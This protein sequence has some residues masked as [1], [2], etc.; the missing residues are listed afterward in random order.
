MELC[1]Q[2]EQ[3]RASLFLTCFESPYTKSYQ[4]QFPAR[5]KSLLEVFQVPI[6]VVP[7]KRAST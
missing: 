7:L 5:G 1:A 4:N 3:K 2:D 6:N